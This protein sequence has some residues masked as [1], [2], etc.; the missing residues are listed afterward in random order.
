MS[1]APAEQTVS[2]WKYSKIKALSEINSTLKTKQ[3]LGTTTIINVQHAAE[4]EEFISAVKLC[5]T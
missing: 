5:E 3:Q 1:L 2:V 4:Q